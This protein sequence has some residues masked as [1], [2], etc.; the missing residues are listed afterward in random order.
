LADG[1]VFMKSVAGPWAIRL[2]PSLAD[3]P[4]FYAKYL[5]KRFMFIAAKQNSKS[6]ST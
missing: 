4:I 2:G 1:P 5:V 3:G 6:M